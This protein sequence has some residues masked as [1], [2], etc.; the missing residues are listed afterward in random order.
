MAYHWQNAL[1]KNGLPTYESAPSRNR[2]YKNLETGFREFAKG[3]KKDIYIKAAQRDLNTFHLLY[4]G[5]RADEWLYTISK[6]YKDVLGIKLEPHSPVNNIGEY[7]YTDWN[8][9]NTVIPNLPNND[10]QIV[11]KI[12]GQ[13]HY[14]PNQNRTIDTIIIHSAYD[15]LDEDIY[16]VDGV[17][18]DSNFILLAHIILLQGME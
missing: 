7:I 17:L 3:I 5:Y 18:Y 13:N 11:D 1:M 4:V 12:I 2:K 9:P 6:V 15:T 10:L 16:S 14:T 8:K